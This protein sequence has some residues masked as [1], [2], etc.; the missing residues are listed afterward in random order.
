[1][2]AQENPNGSVQGVEMERPR[3]LL[4]DDELA[5]LDRIQRLLEGEFRI[6]G[7]VQ[8]G[9]SLVEAARKLD[10]DLIIADISMPGLN[11]FQAARRLKGD[12]PA[13]KII[14]LTVHE[15]WVAVS[16]ALKI[17]VDG[18]VIKRSAGRDL[19][20]AIREVLEGHCFISPAARQ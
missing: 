2:L 5:M 9:E 4:A 6:V 11:G 3:I 20:P 16:E 18:Y 13:I 17:G 7:R 15:E 8:D 12:A 14:F 1:M 19:V 10:P